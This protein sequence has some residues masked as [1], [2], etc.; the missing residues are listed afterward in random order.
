MTRALLALGSNLGDRLNLLRQAR[1]R[2][3]EHPQISLKNA[4]AIYETEPLGGPPGQG[5][6]LNA[7]L[8][9][10]TCLSPGE[11]LASCQEVEERC[12]RVRAERWGPR[13]VDIDILFYGDRVVR[14]ADLIIPHPRLHERRFVLAPL[15]D[16]VPDFIHPQLDST[17]RELLERLAPCGQ[18][19]TLYAKDW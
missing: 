16:L 19:V 3:G 11:L 9:I 10:S 13:S 1:R 4:S 6:Y 8:E 14:Q 7:A 2:I 15:V 12:G 5:P 17:C 18:D